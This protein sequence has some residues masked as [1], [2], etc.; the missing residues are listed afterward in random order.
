[1]ISKIEKKSQC[2]KDVKQGADKRAHQTK[3][4]Q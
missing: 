1:M 4:Q 2:Q 3:E